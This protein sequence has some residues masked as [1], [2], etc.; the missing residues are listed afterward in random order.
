MPVAK[1]QKIE[2]L[3]PVDGIGPPQLPPHV[4]NAPS[5]ID[6]IKIIY[7]NTYSPHLDRFLETVWFDRK[8]MIKLL[9]DGQLCAKFSVLIDRYQLAGQNHPT[10]HSPEELSRTNSLEA[11]VVWGLLNLCR[12]GNNPTNGQY[13]DAE[14]MVEAMKR[15]DVFET[16]LAGQHLDVNPFP[17]SQRPSDPNYHSQTKHREQEFWRLV[18]QFLTLRDD[19]AS[20]AKEIDNTLGSIRLLLDSR[21]NRDVIYSICIARHI[22]QRYSEFPDNLPQPDNND[23]DDEKT[24][25]TVAKSFIESE[26]KGN[27]TN[28]VI[29]RLCGM[30]MR[31]WSAGR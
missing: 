27:G 20:A 29:Q 3:F 4:N 13:Y 17:V 31:S 2:E 11:S 10:A 23:E 12:Q 18:A 25:L 21:E 22:G 19:E 8:G 9:G 30:A 14:G 6:E 1:R 7:L 15:L 24:K 16:L 28:Q 5:R 26:A